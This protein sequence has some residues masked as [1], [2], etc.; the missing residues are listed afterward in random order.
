MIIPKPQSAQH[1]EGE[2]RFTGELPVYLAYGKDQGYGHYVADELTQNLRVATGLFVSIRH[3]DPAHAGPGAIVLTDHGADPA[4]GAEGYALTVASDR[5][6][7]SATDNAGLFYA[8]QSLNQLLNHHRTSAAQGRDDEPTIDSLPCIRIQDKPRFGWR[9]FMLDSAR[10]FQPIELIYQ[11]VNQ[12]SALKL[13]R[14]HWHLTDD[15]G[16]RIEILG[17]PKL[18]GVGAWRTNGQANRPYGGYYTQQ[19]IRELVAY[20][21]VRQI[22][23]IPEIDMPSHNLAAL[24]AYPELS[25]TGEP[26]AVPTA[27]GLLDGAYCAG[28]DQTFVFLKNVLTEV[29]ALFPGSPIHVGGDERKPGVWESCKRCSQVIDNQGLAD[30]SALQK[31]FM[32]RIAGHIHKTLGRRSISWG[33]N[34]DSG[35]SDGMIVQG[36]VP[37]Q[38]AK[39]AQ[40]G[41]DT[42]NSTNEWVYLDYPQCPKEHAASYPDWM[43]TLPTEKVYQFDPIPEDLDPKYH[44]H[45]LGSEANLWTEFVPDQAQLYHQI[46]PR[47][48]AFSEVLWSPPE[49]RDFKDFSQRLT[50]Q[51]SLVQD[52]TSAGAS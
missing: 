5:I 40:Q 31:W 12:M 19:Q 27:W 51:R 35:G 26:R 13:N 28:N 3:D 8:H 50:I 6:T 15:Q 45:I 4:L 43:K 29:A 23:I 1:Q 48:F 32:D 7:L 46:M 2:F 18:T 21:A 17:Y 39:A 49:Q 34:I 41:L 10:H 52:R 44:A 47:L 36:W 22:T 20:A 33:D 24:A 9:G 25:C 16:W 30:E 37:G 11:L 14:F 42:I 38:A